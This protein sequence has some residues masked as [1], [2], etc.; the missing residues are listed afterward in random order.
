[1]S[2]EREIEPHCWYVSTQRKAIWQ[3]SKCQSVSTG[4]RRPEDYRV[5]KV[6]TGLSPQG[7]KVYYEGTC[8]EV[9]AYRAAQEVMES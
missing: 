6:A 3:C 1:M 7:E 9:A 5:I 8:A 4:D 2:L